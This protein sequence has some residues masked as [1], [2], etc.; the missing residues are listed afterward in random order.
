MTRETWNGQYL[1]SRASEASPVVV[2]IERE[3]L[4]IERHDAAAAWWRYADVLLTQGLRSGEPVRIELSGTEEALVIDDRSFLDS[5]RRLAPGAALSR[6]AR[7]AAAQGA[8]RGPSAPAEAGGGA[9]RDLPTTRRSR[10]PLWIGGTV[11]AVVAA[12]LW[13]LPAIGG[14]LALRVPVAWEVDLGNAIADELAPADARCDDPTLVGAV[15]SIVARLATALP[16]SPYAFRVSIVDDTLVNAFAAPG[17]RIVVMRGLLQSSATP[18]EL[19]GVLAHEMQHVELRHGTRALARALPLQAALSAMGGS[20]GGAAA[21]AGT[22]GVLRY[23]RGDE[24]EADR[25]GMRLL[26]AAAVDPRGMI[27]FFETLEAEA[28]ST[29]PAL[30]Y[31]STHPATEDRRAE[32]SRLMAESSGRSSPIELPAEWSALAASC[33]A[34]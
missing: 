24:S 22:L 23:A 18:E 2:T 29:S 25:E 8:A 10:A 16:E 28:G 5:V 31:F 19:A 27:T 1:G 20:A 11:A 33:H 4:R 13:V 17:G 9:A 7:H 3:T 12:Y 32:L 26:M 15:E 21:M 34:S 14:L 6:S 30:T